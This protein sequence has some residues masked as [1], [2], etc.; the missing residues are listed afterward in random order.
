MKLF[1]ARKKDRAEKHDLESRFLLFILLFFF[2]LFIEERYKDG[3][4]T[5]VVILSH[6]FLLDQKKKN[7]VFTSFRLYV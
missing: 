3:K 2:P 5:K 4:I 6:A 7:S 1:T